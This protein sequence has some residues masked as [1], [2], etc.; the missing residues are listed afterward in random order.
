MVHE[1]GRLLVIVT[2][3]VSETERPDLSEAV[4]LIVWL[5]RDRLLVA[6]VSKPGPEVT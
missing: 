3:I 4:A 5:P 6:Y 1:G 2:E